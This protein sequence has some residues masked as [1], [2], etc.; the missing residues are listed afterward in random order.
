MTIAHDT[1]TPILIMVYVT[2]HLN[3]KFDTL[4]SCNCAKDSFL[5]ELLGAAFSLSVIMLHAQF[6]LVGSLSWS[7]AIQCRNG[8]SH[9][10]LKYYEVNNLGPSK[11]YPECK[12]A[13]MCNQENFEYYL[14]GVYFVPNTVLYDMRF[15]FTCC[16]IPGFI[17]KYTIFVSSKNYS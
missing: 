7:L 11:Q 1:V 3:K 10:L 17:L 6:P 4:S 2:D 9:N 14:V 13:H 5:P 12:Q 15:C 16:K 8:S